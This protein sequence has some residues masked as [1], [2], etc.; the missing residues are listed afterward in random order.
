MT[1]RETALQAISRYKLFISTSYF[2]RNSR[3]LHI[4]CEG[5]ATTRKTI[6]QQQHLVMKKSNIFNN[7][8]NMY[9]L[10]P[11]CCCCY[12][13][14]CLWCCC[15]KLEIA[16]ATP[17]SFFAHLSF[18]HFARNALLLPLLYCLLYL[19]QLF[20]RSS[21]VFKWLLCMPIAGETCRGAKY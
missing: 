18:S 11:Y 20:L 19:P 3:K 7:N 16:K 13:S 2:V 6:K 21:I 15:S 1:I 8:S 10:L 9:V 12:C 4:C 14:C 5:R 17:R